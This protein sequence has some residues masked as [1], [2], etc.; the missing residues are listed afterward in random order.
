MGL[1]RVCASPSLF[2]SGLAALGTDPS[3]SKAWLSELFRILKPWCI[4]HALCMM[5]KVLD[6]SRTAFWVCLVFQVYL[7]R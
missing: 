1:A 7:N 5:L 2:S 6:L 4:V 3:R